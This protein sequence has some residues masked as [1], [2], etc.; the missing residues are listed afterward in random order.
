MMQKYYPYAPETHEMIEL[1][2]EINELERLLR[3]KI[4]H[5]NVL[6]ESSIEDSVKV[7]LKPSE[8]SLFQNDMPDEK[9]PFH[10][11]FSDIRYAVGRHN[12]KI[13]F[14]EGKII[15]RHSNGAYIRTYT[16]VSDND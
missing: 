10:K 13:E 5:Y 3:H 4:K 15:L 7:A 11:V 14:G 16:K 9:K 8:D 2:Q 12:A 1:E 6:S